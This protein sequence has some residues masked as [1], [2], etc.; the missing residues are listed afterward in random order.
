MGN[1]AV[2]DRI[3]EETKQLK[4]DFEVQ[5]RKLNKQY[6]SIYD[7]TRTQALREHD[8]IVA[9]AKSDAAVTLDKARQNIKEKVKQAELQIK[10]EIPVIGVTMASKVLGKEMS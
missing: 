4:S 8:R 1:E 6:K 10:K 3:V 9:A 5:A 7:Q 2:A